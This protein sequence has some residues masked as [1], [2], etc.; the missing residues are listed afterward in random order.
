MGARRRPGPRVRRRALATSTSCA[1]SRALGVRGAGERGH[2]HGRRRAGDARRRRRSRRARIGRAR[3]RGG[4]RSMR[5]RASRPDRRRHRGGRGAA[6][7]HGEPTGGSPAR[8]DARAGWWPAGAPAFLVTAVARVGTPQ[9]PDVA[10]VKR[11]VRAGRPVIAAGGIASIDDLE[12]LR[13]VGGRRRR[14]GPRRPRGWA[15]PR[16]GAE[17]SGCGRAA[18]PAT[19]LSVDSRARWASSPTSSPRCDATSPSIPSTTGR[20]S[21]ARSARPPARDF[22]A[23]L[24]ERTPALIA[25]VKRASPS[26]G[27][28]ADDADPI[29]QAIA[30]ADGRRRG[31][32]G[33]DRAPALPRVARRPRGRRG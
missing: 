32:L 25:E 5:S 2:P 4:D 23:A 18:D 20:C 10:A 22:V 16:R 24:R 17:R 31:D 8:R 19:D 27:S 6:S 21:P 1:R 33:A 28:I 9:G 7:D 26:A 13:R 14:R 3:R 30:Y 11:V 29:A 15:R 12:G